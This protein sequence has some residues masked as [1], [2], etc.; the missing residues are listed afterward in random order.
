V[1]FASQTRG[2]EAGISGHILA[3]NPDTGEFLWDFQTIEE[4]F[5][6]HPEVNSGGGVWYA[7]AIDTDTGM[8][9]WG[10]GNPAPFPGTLD[11]PNASSRLFPNLYTNAVLALEYDS[12]ELVW[13]NHLNPNDLFDLDTQ[14]PPILATVQMQAEDR[15]IVI[16]SGKFGRVVAMDRETGGVL[17]DTLVGIHQNDD[18][19]EVPPGETVV[20]YPGVYGGVETPMAYADG[21]VYA[22]VLNLPTEYEATAFGAQNGTEAVQNAGEHTPTGQGTSE[23]VALDASTGQV[24]WS[25][26]FP[27]DMYGGATVVNDLVFV[28]TFDG[29][30][31]ALNRA[32]GE[33]VWSYQAP[34]GINAWPAVADDTIIWPAGFGGEPVLIALRL[35]I[36][37]DATAPE[38]TE[39][40]AHEGMEGTPEATAPAEG[41]SEAGGEGTPEATSEPAQGGGQTQDTQFISVDAENQTVNLTV[42]AALDGSNGGLNFNGFA[43]GNAT[44]IVPQGWT[45][46]VHFENQSSLPHSAI[47]VPQDAVSQNDLPEP[48]FSGASTADPHAGTTQPEDFSVTAQEQGTYAMACAVP[49]HAAQGQWIV[50]EVGGSDAEPSFQPGTGG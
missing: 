10:T 19:V 48:V 47:I 14:L 43:N 27:T 37:P 35:P 44:Y 33:T 30:I 18:L 6:G 4:G 28:A 7:P 26:E 49:G 11:Y 24:R 38:A 8:T 3:L 1:Y 22:P 46:N 50:F 29:M 21:T 42:I 23:V 45:V 2:Y 5:W 36:Q 34:A 15:E 40:P 41:T 13:Y 20:V 32:S 31:Y 9:F 39:P 16:G 25:H 12:G 17:W